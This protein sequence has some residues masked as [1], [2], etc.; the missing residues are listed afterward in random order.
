M[1][2]NLNTYIKHDL[3]KTEN[4]SYYFIPTFAFTHTE[5]LYYHEWFTSYHFMKFDVSRPRVLE[6]SRCPDLI[7]G[8]LRTKYGP[9]IANGPTIGRHR[10]PVRLQWRIVNLTFP[11]DIYI[12]HG[13]RLHMVQNFQLSAEMRRSI[14]KVG[15]GSGADENVTID[16]DRLHFPE[17]EGRRIVQN[18]P[19]L[20]HF[21]HSVWRWD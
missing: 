9:L 12:K 3:R 13:L 20:E 17:D 14:R 6:I 19:G 18:I 11:F 1:T 7:A 4:P 21:A 10:D 5:I 8:N 16:H 2:V 15:G